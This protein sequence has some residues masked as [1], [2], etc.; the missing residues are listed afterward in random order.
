MAKRDLTHVRDNRS[1]EELEEYWP[2]T[3]QR[4]EIWADIICDEMRFKTHKNVTYEN[5]GCGHDGKMIRNAEDVNS[6]PDKKFII[7]GK[8]ILI[9]IKAYDRSN[10]NQREMMT[11][12]THS[13]KECVKYNAFIVVPSVSAWVIF[14]PTGIEYLL[15][16]GVSKIYPGFSPNDLAIRMYSMDVS[17]MLDSKAISIHDWSLDSKNKI[18]KNWKKLFIK[19]KK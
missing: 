12:K 13:L 10:G 18:E 9:E 15:G 5:Y 17:V 3:D 4:E 11:I 2:E 8:E 6:K 1:E 14:T 16:Y 19:E 7:D